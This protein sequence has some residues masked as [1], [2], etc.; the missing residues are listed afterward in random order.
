MSDLDRFE[1]FAYVAQSNSLTQAAKKLK[2]AK[3]SLSK[4]IKKLEK[5]LKIDLFSRTGQRLYLT[6]NGQLLLE[7][8]KRLQKELDE[9]RSIC[10][11]FQEEP[12]GVLSIVVFEYFA[13]KIIFPK[14][15]DFLKQYPRLEIIIDINERIPDFEKEKKDLAVGFSLLPPSDNIIQKSMQKTRYVLCAS[16]KYFAE[17]GV[18]ETLHDL[19]AHKYICHESR[20]EPGQVIKLKPNYKLILKPTIILNRAIAMI[21]CARVG[22]G[23]IQL[24]LYMTESLLSTGELVEVLKNY[25]ADDVGVYY[26]YPKFRYTQPKVRKFIDYFLL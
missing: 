1:L 23:L 12:E 26:Y 19:C 10:K 15:N 22:L 3:A 25:Q 7:Q 5:D 13:N 17:N 6:P 2:M 9:T 11:Q 21:E 24:P 14:L 8:C 18:P 16:P 4:K 20:L